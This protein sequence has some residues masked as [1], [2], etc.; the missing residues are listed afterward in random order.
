M[1][2]KI[3]RRK[4]LG[5]GSCAAIG[6]TTFFST[7][8][9]L[10][11]AGAASLLAPGSPPNDYRAMVCILLGGGNDSFNMIVPRGSS[12]Y[13]E[14]AQVRSNL[15]TFKNPGGGIIQAGV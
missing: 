11:L 12:E 9:D 1:K 13:N 7:W 5:Q 2:N 15:V 6:L 8:M 4:F 3:T 14:Y 10:Q